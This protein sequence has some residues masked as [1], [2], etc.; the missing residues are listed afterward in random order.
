[1]LQEIIKDIYQ[2]KVPLPGNPLKALNSYLIKGQKRSLLVD[3]GFNWPECK[4][5][6][7][8]AMAELGLDW[9]QIDFF[10]TH[11][12]GD[13]SGLVYELSSKDSIVYC[14]RTDADLLQECMEPSYWERAN[15]FYIQH[16]YPQEEIRIQEENPSS[17]ISGSEIDFSYVQDQD[18][19][20]VGDYHL[21]CIATP[22]HS[23]GHMCLYEPK[24]KFL[25]AWDHIL[26]SISSNITHWG[27]NEDYLGLYLSSL[28]KVKVLDINLV[29]PGHREIIRNHRARILEL[30]QHHEKRLAEILNILKEGPMNAYQVAG[31]MN[32]DVKCKSWEEFPS[33]QKWF[34]TGE[35]IAHLEHLAALNKIQRIQQEGIIIYR[36]SIGFNV[37]NAR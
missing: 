30:N 25:I 5:A 32:W 2:I 4:K 9:A 15:A 18:M 3:T 31:N 28:D 33:Y 34:A 17:W 13:H 14:S 24:Y 19:I 35:A 36:P 7:M 23:P 26:G 16:G 21:I 37:N 29:L 20:E 1:M 8:D 6:Q 12:H 11:I 22:G 27:G 10:I